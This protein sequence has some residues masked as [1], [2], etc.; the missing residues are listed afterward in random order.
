MTE[1]GAHTHSEAEVD[2]IEPGSE[3]LFFLHVPFLSPHVHSLPV[4][5][6]RSSSPPLLL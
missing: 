4:P 5:G 3:H 2:P 6:A 1:S